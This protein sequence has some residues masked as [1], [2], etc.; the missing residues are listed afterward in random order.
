MAVAGT[1]WSKSLEGGYMGE[2]GLVREMMNGS[3]HDAGGFRV[4]VVVSHIWLFCPIAR[5][6]G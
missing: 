3:R 4:R 2:G 1:S 5:G 6:T